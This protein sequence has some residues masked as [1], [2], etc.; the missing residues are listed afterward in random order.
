MKLTGVDVQLGK[1]VSAQDLID[2][3]FDKI[4][5]A[6]GVSPRKLKIDGSDNPKVTYLFFD[7]KII[8]TSC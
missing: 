5:M 2:G 1:R 6:T 4:V 3:G 8:P 7:S